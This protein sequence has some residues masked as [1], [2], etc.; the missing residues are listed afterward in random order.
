MP[1]IHSGE[2]RISS[3][4]SVGKIE[5]PNIKGWNWIISLHNTQKSTYQIKDLRSET[6]KLLEETGRAFDFGLD[7]GLLDVTSKAQ[8]TKTKIDP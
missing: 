4:N 6:V 8:V 1:R 5:Y 3:K 2:S 7:S